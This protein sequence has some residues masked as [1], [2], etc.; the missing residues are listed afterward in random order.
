VRV[1]KALEEVKSKLMYPVVYHEGRS[2]SHKFDDSTHI[3]EHEKQGSVRLWDLY[4]LHELIHALFHEA[5]PFSIRFN[6]GCG[7]EWCLRSANDWFANAYMMELCPRETRIWMIRVR[8]EVM[9]RRKP[10]ASKHHEKN[11]LVLGLW[12]AQSAKFLNSAELPTIQDNDVYEVYGIFMRSPTTL[13]FDNYF[14]IVKDLSNV[15]GRVV[16]EKVAD[17]NGPHWDM[18]C[19][20]TLR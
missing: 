10:G 19:K 16:I 11:T 14:G 2:F 4:L 1:K 20:A 12:F 13:T 8:D 9:R 6:V 7:I 17:N 3:I 15:F 5:F 18:T